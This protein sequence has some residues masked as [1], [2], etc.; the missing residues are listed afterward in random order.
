MSTMFNK[1][2]LKSRIDLRI[3]GVCVV[4][5][6]MG[7]V[8]RY[9]HDIRSAYEAYTEGPIPPEVSRM[10]L[11]DAAA[12][13][14]AEAAQPGVL[15]SAPVPTS[16]TAIPGQLNLYVLFI[17]QAPFQVW[18]AIHE[19]TC[20]EATMLMARAFVD[21]VKTMTRQEMDTRLL[22]V[23][24]YENK[25]LHKFEDTSS[26]ETAQIMTDLL[27]LKVQV[28][29][30]KNIDDI[31]R[32]IAAGHV[33]LLP[34]SGK[35]LNNPHYRGGGPLYHMLLAKGYTTDRIIVNDPGTKN[36]ANYTYSND[37]IMNALADWNG[38][39]VDFNQ[40]NMIVVE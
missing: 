37:T 15:P 25:T 34:M 36:G 27:G 21:N 23:V 5:V 30:V 9:R 7:L 18:D 12:N 33:V 40:K 24:A 26:A 39:G 8:Y 22:Q 29:A 2:L 11:P 10:T 20:E 6:T 19:D 35:A 28:V 38:T 32:Q 17:P 14:Q 1:K 4:L 3:I 16:R 31:K 13:T